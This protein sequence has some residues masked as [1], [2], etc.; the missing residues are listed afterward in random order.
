[1]Y[2]ADSVSADE[3]AG[4]LNTIQCRFRAY[5]SH[6]GDEGEAWEFPGHY[7]HVRVFYVYLHSAALYTPGLATA[8][9]EALEGFDRW[10]CELECYSAP[11]TPRRAMITPVFLNGDFYMEENDL[12]EQFAAALKLAIDKSA[13]PRSLWSRI[14]RR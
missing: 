12:P 8:V 6:L 10:I 1:M 4:E 13:A 5:I 9:G 14:F 7:Q 11:T 2:L 3:V